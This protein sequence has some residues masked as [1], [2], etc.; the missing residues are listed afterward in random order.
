MSSKPEP[1]DRDS[2]GILDP[3]LFRQRVRLTRYPVSAALAGLIDRFWAV[4]WDLPVDV[5]HR[6]QVLTHPAAN[7]SVSHPDA[8]S[9]ASG[10]PDDPLGGGQGQRLEARLSGVATT[11]S[12]RHL[13]GR[14]WAVAAM[15]TP[16]GLGAFISGSVADLT[17]RIVAFD[18]VIDVDEAGL[19]HRLGNEP[20]EAARVEALASALQTALIPQR[21][22]TARQ[23]AEV[24]QLAETDRSV[25]RLA[26]LSAR[27]GVPSRTLQRLFAQYAGVSPTWV[28]RRYRLLDVAEAVRS[29]ESPVWADVAVGLGYADQAHLV[30]DFR[31]AT[32]QTPARYASSQRLR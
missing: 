23:V 10:T 17:D 31:A 2:R 18:G 6:Q 32:G 19:L 4:R 27:T 14:G 20:N 3:L 16:G 28:L 13:S 26:D 24:A 11:L 8:R 15:T 9:S 5:V 1:V 29:G 21:V 12:T 7:L 25:R 22:A 30:R